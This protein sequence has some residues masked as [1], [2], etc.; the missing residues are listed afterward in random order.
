MKF[1]PIVKEQLPT[2]L[3]YQA[4]RDTTDWRSVENEAA[5]EGLKGSLYAVCVYDEN[6]IVGMGRVI[7]DGGLYYYIQDMIVA[8]DY[9]REGVGKLILGKLMNY[10]NDVAQNNAFVGLMAAQGSEE[11]YRKMGFQTRTKDRPG[12]YL[13]I[14]K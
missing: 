5:D 12:M 8:P 2:V 3:E 4:L 11:F 1:D 7:G 10:I 14:V 6:A 9:H 13:E